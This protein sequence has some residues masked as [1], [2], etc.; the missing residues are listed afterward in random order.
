MALVDQE[1]AWLRLSTLQHFAYCPRQAALLIDGVWADNY[2]TVQGTAGHEH[3]DSGKTDYRRGAIVHH[4]VPLVCHRWRIRG[5]ADAIEQDANGTLMPV[6]HKR[7]RGAGDEFPSI[8]QVVGQALCLEEMLG[9]TVPEVALYITKER[10]RDRYRT[11]D[12]RTRVIALIEEARVRLRGHIDPIFQARL[13][14]SCSVQNA[15]QPRGAQ[16]R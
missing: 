6:E 11:D 12:Y 7:G 8:V 5:V 10:R 16:W 2:L 1:D 14:T 13:C 9:S 3:V 15:C 4:R